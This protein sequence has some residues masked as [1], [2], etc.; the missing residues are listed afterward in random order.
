[1]PIRPSSLD[2]N[3][4]KG[5]IVKSPSA[6]D[7]S[8]HIMVSSAARLL[9][10][11]LGSG[12]TRN[13]APFPV[14]RRRGAIMRFS[15]HLMIF[16][17]GIIL[18]STSSTFSFAMLA[19]IYSS[20][21]SGRV[22]RVFLYSVILTAAAATGALLSHQ[23]RRLDLRGRRYLSPTIDS[24]QC[25]SLDSFVL[26][27]RP[28]KYDKVLERIESFNPRKHEIIT[29]LLLLSKL[30]RE[31]QLVSAFTELG[32]VVAVGK[33]GEDLPKAGAIRLYLEDDKWRDAVRELMAKAQQV[34]MVL[35]SGKGLMW[36]L[37]T[38][39]EVVRPD[40]LTLIFLEDHTAYLQFRQEFSQNI[41]TAGGRARTSVRKKILPRVEDYPASRSNWARGWLI[42]YDEKWNSR[43]AMLNLN[44]SFGRQRDIRRKIKRAFRSL[45]EYPPPLCTEGLAHVYSPSDR[46]ASD[47][48]ASITSRYPWT[49]RGTT[50]FF[51]PSS[52][53]LRS[54]ATYVCTS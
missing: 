40:R 31:E 41:V 44:F 22:S 36:E 27:L 53:N 4:Q 7:W 52:S 37:A 8:S 38:A 10:L 14:P 17:G 49:V 35:G 21:G 42:R 1:M 23:G 33:P 2:I 24:A 16:V 48:P 15:A 25:L 9:G 51:G 32:L 29:E 3:P 6:E 47:W 50:E 30:T 18:V 12:M 5:G 54:P 39:L 20:N 43:Y 11:G 46:P 26:Y 13:G 34:V 45:E 19:W 28:F